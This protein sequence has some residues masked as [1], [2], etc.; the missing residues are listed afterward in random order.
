MC[1][2]TNGPSSLLQKLEE[3]LFGMEENHAEVGSPLTRVTEC[4][5]S[6][7]YGGTQMN[8]SVTLKLDTT[9]AASLAVWS[10]LTYRTLLPRAFFLTSV[11]T[12]HL[13]CPPVAGCCKGGCFFPLMSYIE[14]FFSSA[15]LLQHF[16]GGL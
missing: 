3:F 16:G 9:S 15:A 7:S 6:V 14:F 8:Q 5:E 13:V 10:M 11:R 2:S 1:V 4:D 12:E